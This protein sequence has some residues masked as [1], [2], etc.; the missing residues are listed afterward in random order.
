MSMYCGLDVSNKSTAICVIDEKGQIILEAAAATNQE[1]LSE[2]LKR[3][4]SLK[5]VV[6]AAPLAETVCKWIERLGHE[7]DVLDPRRAKAVTATKRKTDRLDAMN[8]AQVCRTGWFTKVHRKS[9]KARE[10]RSCL[11]ARHELVKLR[12]SLGSGIRGIL[13]AN[14]IIL[15]LNKDESFEHGVRA[16]LKELTVLMRHS[17]QLLLVSWIDLDKREK[18]LKRRLERFVTKERLVPKNLE[19]VPGV[20]AL[21]ASAFVATIDDPKRFPTS[22]Q[23]GP[24]LGLVPSL[25][26]SGET[27]IRGRITKEGDKLLRWLLIESATVIL[28]RCKKQFALKQW[29]AQLQEKKGFGK[30]RVAVARKLAVLL[31]HLWL[32]GESFKFAQTDA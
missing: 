11:T 3:F 17:I 2:A 13:R 9:V 20:G 25:Y 16:A 31:H 23:V 10:L 30:A 28:S 5:C 21:T 19:S 27:E 32:S 14:G 7:I 29:G 4:K 26:Q 12:Q 18:E 1:G 6:E 8:L 24:Y 22:G 15:K